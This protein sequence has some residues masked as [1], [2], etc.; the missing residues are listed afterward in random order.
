[1][2][3]PKIILDEVQQEEIEFYLNSM[4]ISELSKVQRIIKVLNRS[5]SLPDVE[6]ENKNEDG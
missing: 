6:P 1:M 3:K 5:H 4:P 2:S